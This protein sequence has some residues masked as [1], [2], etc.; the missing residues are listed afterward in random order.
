MTALVDVSDAHEGERVNVNYAFPLS[1]N[2]AKSGIVPAVGLD[3]QS[4]S[5]NDYYYG[6]SAAESAR[7]GGSVAA[8][9]SDSSVNPYFK[10][11]AYYEIAPQWQAVANFRYTWLDD[12]ISDSS[13][14]ED[15]HEARV[16]LGVKYQF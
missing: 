5:Y 4:N 11:D 7:T 3:W 12:E 8:Y 2:T 10:V 9:D 15:D 1:S 13:M 6:V 16:S 14:V